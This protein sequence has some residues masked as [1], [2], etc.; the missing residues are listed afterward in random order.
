MKQFIYIS[1]CR[2][3]G[4]NKVFS[5]DKKAIGKEFDIYVPELSFAIEP[6]SWYWHKTKVEND[7]Q[8][9]ELCKKKWN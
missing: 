5:R 8:K 9:R 3:L 1:L 7:F 2:I 6:G 4:S